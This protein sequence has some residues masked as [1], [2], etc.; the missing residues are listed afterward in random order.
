V[1]APAGFSPSGLP[2]GIQIIAPAHEDMRC[3]QLGAAYEAA[4]PLWKTHAP[5]MS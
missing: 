5:T 1:A 3:L 2:M 4:N